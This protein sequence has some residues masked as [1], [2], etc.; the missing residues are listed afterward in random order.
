MWW[1]GIAGSKHPAQGRALNTKAF[2]Q[3]MCVVVYHDALLTVHIFYGLGVQHK[4][5]MSFLLSRVS[6]VV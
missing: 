3:I 1:S 6:F 4:F 2:I 5:L